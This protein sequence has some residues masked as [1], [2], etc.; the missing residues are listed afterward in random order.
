MNRKW[1]AGFTFCIFI[2]GLTLLRAQSPAQSDAQGPVTAPAPG[3]WLSGDPGDAQFN[4]AVDPGTG[5]LP[6]PASG[7]VVFLYGGGPDVALASAGPEFT[8]ALPFPGPD[9]QGGPPAGGVAFVGPDAQ[10]N[11]TFV[12]F[13]AGLG[14]QTVT[15]APYSAQITS[16][17]EQTLSDG[18]KIDRKTATTVYR[19]GQGR[20]RREQTLPAIGPYAASTTPPQAIFINDPVAG[21][22]YVLDPVHKTARKMPR[23]N[24]LPAVAGQPGPGGPGR[25]PGRGP[26]GPGG[27]PPGNV[28][29]GNAGPGPG[30]RGPGGPPP[31][32]GPRPQDANVNTE[33][34]GNQNIEGILVQGTRVTRSIPAGTVGNQQ[35]IQVTNERWYSPDLKLNL[36]VKSVDPMRGTNTTTLSNI[37]RDEPAASLFQVPADYT[38]QEPPKGPRMMIR[39]GAP[40][41]PT[42]PQ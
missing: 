34:L 14:N 33:S 31:G 12:G 29:Q 25:G 28:P 40:P 7:D 39:K 36:V 10:N 11:I 2:L 41:P 21:V 20:T 13:E 42:P 8:A 15:G 18:N 24:I 17:F 3:L 1:L 6:D 5:T 37:R 30:R 4:I 27:P 32:N 19:D 22:T 16:E 26:G 35:P 38:V 23:P 9:P